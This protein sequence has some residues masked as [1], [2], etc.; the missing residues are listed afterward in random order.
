MQIDFEAEP[1]V[2]QV[3]PTHFAKT[4]LLHDMAQEY[5]SNLRKRDEQIR[6]RQRQEQPESF[7]YAHAEQLVSIKNLSVAFK[8]N[9]RTF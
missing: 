6:A 7:D 4:W 3:T 9:H 2:F 1:P 8:L 5:A